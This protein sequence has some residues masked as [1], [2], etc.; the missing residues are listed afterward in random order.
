[1]KKK[2]ISKDKCFNSRKLVHLP[3]DYTVLNTYKKNKSD[4]SSIKP[5]NNN[6][7]DQY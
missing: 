2:A 5:S 3:K 7:R 1:M 4:K 6:M